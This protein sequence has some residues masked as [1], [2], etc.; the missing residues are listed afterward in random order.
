MTTE[1]PNI[2][3][4]P[5][6]GP[7]TWN[8]ARTRPHSTLRLRLQLRLRLG[9]RLRLPLRLPLRRAHRRISYPTLAPSSAYAVFGRSKFFRVDSTQ[10]LVAIRLDSIICGFALTRLTCFFVFSIR[11]DSRSTYLFSTRVIQFESN[12]RPGV[13]ESHIDQDVFEIFQH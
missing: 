3:K 10:A 13:R 4:E 5:L 2:W 12:F 6:H 7:G 9:L 11:V 1:S 8:P